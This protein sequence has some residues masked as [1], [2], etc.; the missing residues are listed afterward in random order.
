[1]QLEAL[2]G[3]RASSGLKGASR[4]PRVAKTR[5]N[6]GGKLHTPERRYQ[7]ILGLRGLTGMKPR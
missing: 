7:S 1:M 3:L 2:I 4:G 6:G 5:L